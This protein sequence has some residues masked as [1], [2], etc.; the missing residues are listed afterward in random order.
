MM[1]SESKGDEQ[2]ICV[3]VSAYA[4]Y[5]FSHDVAQLIKDYYKN[6]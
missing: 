3:F 6:T 1:C 5:R 4:E 2:L